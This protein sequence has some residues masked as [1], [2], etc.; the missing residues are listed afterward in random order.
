[1][2]AVKTADNT[3]IDDIAYFRQAQIPPISQLSALYARARRT[4]ARIIFFLREYFFPAG[5]ALCDSAL[6]DLNETWYGICEKCH[7][8][9]SQEIAWMDGA[10]AMENRCN[11]CGKPMVSGKGDC[12]SCRNGQER[13]YDQMLT[14]FS[15][16]GKYRKLF[17][18]YKFGK[19][20]ALGHFFAEIIIK[21]CQLLQ[22]AESENPLHIAPVP[23]RPGKIKTDG[24]DQVEYLA[25]LI[26]AGRADAGQVQRSAFPL[27]RCLKR[28]ASQVQKKL[29][30]NERLQNLS[31]K[32][33]MTRQPPPAVVI[34]DDVITTGSTMDACASALKAGGACKVYGIC[35]VYN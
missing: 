15:Y 10:D 34:I 1:M 30:R 9:L 19:H 12:L 17:G 16:S 14:V 24:W 26:E 13:S 21:A 7:A 3:T 20:L 32:I 4:A 2:T 33:V 6:L 28:L 11:I 25:R 29:K 27:C 8:E 31:G 22:A 5:C 35:L 23:P 18:A